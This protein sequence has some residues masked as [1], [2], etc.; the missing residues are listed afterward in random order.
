MTQIFQ[1][2]PQIFPELRLDTHS[3]THACDP[4]SLPIEFTNELPDLEDVIGQARAFRALDLGS[5]VKGMGFNVFIS[6]SPDSGRTTLTRDFLKRKAASAN[7]PDDW[8]Y[9]NNFEDARAPLCLSLPPS[10][11]IVF[12][13]DMQDLVENCR[14]DIPRAFSSE[15]YTRERDKLLDGMKIL[16]DREVELLDTF[17]REY[18]FLVVKT[19]YGLF[20][21]P[22]KDGKPMEGA[23]FEKLS[24]EMK[25]GLEQ[26]QKTLTTR[27][28]KTLAKLRNVEQLTREKLQQLETKTSMF[29][30]KPQI[31]ALLEKYASVI[32]LVN[33]LVRVQEDMTVHAKRFR[34]DD[35]GTNDE[36]DE[37]EWTL[38]YYV[39]VLVDNGESK[40][41]P[42]IIENQPTYQNL[43]G[44][45]ERDIVLGASYTDF[46]KI[47]AGAMHRANGGYLILPARDLLI[48]PY[49][50]EGLKRVLRDGEIRMLELSSQMGVIRT[51]SL[52]PQPIP[53]NV[54]V[55]MVG[56]P[57][58][59]YLLRAYDEDFAKL[60]KIRSEF[61]MMMARNQES[62]LEYAKFINSVCKVNQLPPFDRSAVARVIEHGSRMVENQTK[63]TTQF[64]L[65]AD[66]ICEAAYW[67]KKEDKQVVDKAAVQKAL[68][69][70]VFRCNLLEERIQEL[71]TEDTLQVNVVGQAVGQINALS[72]ISLGDYNFGRPNRVTAAVYAGQKGV[73]DI[74]RQ[75]KLGGHLHTKGVL[76]INGFLGARFGQKR[77]LNL[78]ASLTFEQSYDEIEGDS[79]SA[80]EL[81]ALLSALS[82][83]PIHQGI[84]ITGSVDQFG[85]IQAIGGVN[86]KVEG[87]FETCRLKGLNGIQGVIIP[88]SNQKHLMLSPAVQEA[89]QDGTFHL[90]A[91]GRIEEAAYLLT[92]KPFGEVDDAG[93]YPSGSLC[94]SVVQRLDAYAKLLKQ[95][96]SGFE[97]E[98]KE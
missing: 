63:L 22:I 2:Y 13:K 75:A 46:T 7:P 81:M 12:R 70:K 11:G 86:E 41:A 19:P 54:K 45:I 14:I 85:Q 77:P 53:L 88:G 67:A 60:F 71:I 65:V 92:G 62:E 18:G 34:S 47:R 40:G 8:C 23:E 90:W 43:L 33:Y 39:N 44:S 37:K 93:G 30:I 3:L 17:V 10:L 48:N 29:I 89:V 51:T 95:G 21:A 32:P 56:T 87:F 97:K 57:S 52:E 28:E 6:G 91:V 79:A 5:E 82:G 61:G 16:F 66:L 50:W 20:L 78:N 68:D 35:K 72:V 74:E 64:G 59:Y 96:T 55:I 24:K 76:I 36:E 73:I 58:L 83:L 94:E 27:M 98:E 31:D 25:E 4:E 9:I 15:E 26:T 49:A 80:A 84:A 1:D 38:R 69:E 42:V